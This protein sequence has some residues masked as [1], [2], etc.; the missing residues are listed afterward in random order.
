MGEYLHNNKIVYRD[1]KLDNVLLDSKGH[2]KLADFGMCKQNVSDT[3][4]CATF[5]G[6]PDYIAP[7]IIR[8][9]LYTFSVDWWS[10]GVLLYE[11]IMGKSPFHGESED[12]LYTNILTHEVT[13]P[14]KLIP[15]AKTCLQSLFIRDA[16]KRLGVTSR[17][18]DH[19]FY[20]DSYGPNLED[21]FLN[22][23]IKPPFEPVVGETY[24]DDE[25]ISADIRL[26]KVSRTPN[27]DEQRFFADFGYT[28]PKLM[29]EYTE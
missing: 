9:K 14:N 6:T 8:G 2:V 16:R 19:K 4:R 3:N 7:E 1:L 18:L 28:C 29:E 27:K 23:R 21:D 10:F 25:F 13:Y 24:F 15:Q 12:D 11:M 20:K 26:S 17:I 22:K 5:C